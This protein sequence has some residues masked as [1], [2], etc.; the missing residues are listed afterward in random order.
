M[1]I[2]LVEDDKK[3]TKA[4]GIR[5]AANRHTFA[6]SAT[7]DSAV[8]DA[9]NFQPDLTIIDINLPGGDGFVVAERLKSIKGMAVTPFIFITASKKSGLRETAT[10]LGAIGFLDKPFAASEL[11]ELIKDCAAA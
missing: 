10:D 5:L 2:L 3:L 8:T 6:S 9:I 1:K 4:I 7:V 11:M